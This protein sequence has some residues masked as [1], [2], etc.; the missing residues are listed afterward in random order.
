VIGTAAT[1]IFKSGI[2]YW[3][4]FV[5]EGMFVFGAVMKLLDWWEMK[6]FLSPDTPRRKL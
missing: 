3:S 1:G 4:T 6:I 5:G 2:F